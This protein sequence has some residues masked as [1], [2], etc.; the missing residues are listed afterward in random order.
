VGAG[1][2]KIWEPTGS[3]LTFN[4]IEWAGFTAGVRPSEFD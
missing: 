4:P 1:Q 2:P 3:A